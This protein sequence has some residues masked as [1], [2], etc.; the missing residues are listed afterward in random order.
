[1][2]AKLEPYLEFL[3]SVQHGKPSL[4]CDFQELYRYLI[5]DFVIQ[6]CP[7]LGKHDFK[8]KR[9]KMSAQKR[10]KREYLNN[11]QT[12]KLIKSLEIFLKSE[13][14]IPRIRHG[15]RQNIETLINEEA[16]LLS[17]YLR[18]EKT[19]WKPRLVNKSSMENNG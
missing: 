19:S 17:K 18:K 7:K 16:L 5:D 4:V 12:R 15:K 6:Y 14:E 10:G 1:M 2:K 3:H 13:I 8:V 11:H 9:E